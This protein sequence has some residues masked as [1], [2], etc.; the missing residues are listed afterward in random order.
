MLLRKGAERPT[1]LVRVGGAFAV[2]AVVV[3]LEHFGNLRVV[4]RLGRG[5]RKQVLF[6]DVRNVIG[7]VVLGEQVVEG[8]VL[9]GPDLLRDRLPPFLGVR[10]L[11]VDVVNNAPERKQAVTHLLADAELGCLVDFHSPRRP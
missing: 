7:G 5:V 11:R 3:D 9:D 4:H 1:R 6:G 8:L 10:E 2:G